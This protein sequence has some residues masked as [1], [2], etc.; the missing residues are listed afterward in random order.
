MG[1]VSIETNKVLKSIEEH[2]EALTK[3]E[4]ILRQNLNQVVNKKIQLFWQ[5]DF[6]LWLTKKW[7]PAE[8]K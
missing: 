3:N 2:I 4:Q 1:K 6:I 7:K 5:K 8:K